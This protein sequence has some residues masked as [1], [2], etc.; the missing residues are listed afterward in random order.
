MRARIRALTSSIVTLLAVA[1]TTAPALAQPR[2][3]AALAAAPASIR[4]CLSA[5]ITVEHA[6]LRLERGGI[7]PR[8]RRLDHRRRAASELELRSDD[9]G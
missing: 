2:R 8:V 6:R 3:S 9:D 4:A 7:S 5:P 1:S